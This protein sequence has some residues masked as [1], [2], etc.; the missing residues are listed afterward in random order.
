MAQWSPAQSD[1]VVEKD[2]EEREREHAALIANGAS[3]TSTKWV[4]IFTGIVI[5]ALILLITVGA[6]HAGGG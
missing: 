2:P 5:V 4:Y 1:V 3:S 6:H